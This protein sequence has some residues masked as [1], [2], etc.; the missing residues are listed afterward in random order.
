[1]SVRVTSSTD[2]RKNLSQM[3]DEVN[4]DH[5]PYIITRSGGKPAVLISLEDYQALDET[6][7]LLASPANAKALKESI[8]RLDKG[9][10]VEFELLDDE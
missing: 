3:M 2:L 1:M 10:G 7:Y 4:D 6:S 5:V 9:E 8:E